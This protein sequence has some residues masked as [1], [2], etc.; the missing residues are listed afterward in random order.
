MH[1]I[2][3]IISSEIRQSKKN[4]GGPFTI[5]RNMVE[6]AEDE[7]YWTPDVMAQALLGI[8]F[9]AAHQPWMNLDFVILELCA[10]PEFINLLREEISDFDNSEYSYQKLEKLPLLDSFIKETIRL[11]PLDTLAVRRKAL[12]TFQF[13]DGPMVPAGTVTCI[14]SYDA[15]H[16]MAT[17]AEPDKFDGRRFMAK[18]KLTDISENF[19]V[20][21]FGSL[22]W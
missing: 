13:T 1:F 18:S 21:G 4:A 8:W 19:P 2:L 12:Q 16:D 22:A 9:A 15:L 11:N 17:Y 10:R 3:N 5:L 7:E 6:L 14:S 20:W